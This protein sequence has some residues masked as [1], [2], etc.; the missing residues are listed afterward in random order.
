MAIGSQMRRLKLPGSGKAKKVLLIILVIVSII[1]I[2]D[3]SVENNKE[4]ETGSQQVFPKEELLDKITDHSEEENKLYNEAF[5]K[6]HSGAYDESINIANDILEKFP[7]SERA[8]NI[9]GIAE[10]FNG[11][12]NQ[13]LIDIN[14]A[15]EL[16]EDYGYALFN[17]A[18]CYELYND[19]ENS[20]IWYDKALSVEQYLWSYYGKAS[21][22][23]RQGNID[24]VE[25]NLKKALEIAEKENVLKEVKEAAKVEEDFLSVRNNDRFVN[26]IN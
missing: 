17:K 26:L 22:Y 18:L 12:F 21:I 11:D 19:Y 20:L 13:G 8:Y 15:I 10:A 5:E 2:I 14:K 6:F 9:K 16:K 25:V 4:E 23:G 1:V 3:Y 24:G 7:M